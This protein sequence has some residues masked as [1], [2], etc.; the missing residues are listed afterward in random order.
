MRSIGSPN[1]K[2][3][4]QQ[5]VALYTAESGPE[6]PTLRA[7]YMSHSGKNFGRKTGGN[8]GTTGRRYRCKVRQGGYTTRSSSPAGRIS[9]K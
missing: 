8:S 6:G 2:E 4:G 9:K 1:P 7:K 5:A 3:A